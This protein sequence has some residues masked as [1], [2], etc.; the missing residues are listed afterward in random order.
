MRALPATLLAILLAG[1]A[2][3]PSPLP[4]GRVPA[5]PP[6]YEAWS[7]VLERH[8]DEQG[9]IDF[10]GVARARADLDRFVAYVYE[11]APDNAPQWFPGADHVLAFHINAYNALAMHKVLEA[12]IPETLAGW[13]RFAFFLAGKVRVGGVRISL[14]DYEFRVIRA[15][16]DARIHAALNCMSVG[17]PRLPREAFRGEDLQTQLDREARRF[18]NEARNVLVD[19]SARVLRVSEILRFHRAHFLESAPSLAAYV[20]RYREVPVPEAY[21]VEFIDYDWTVNR[22]P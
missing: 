22:R 1:C 4:G 13:R 16:G 5:G 7:R 20:N 15:L 9:R 2:A 11:F 6:P 3:V 12:G 8:V 17:C 19:D 21:R 14:Y 10:A 18:F